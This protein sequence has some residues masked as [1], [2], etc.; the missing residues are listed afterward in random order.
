MYRTKA[1]HLIDDLPFFM[2]LPIV[3]VAQLGSDELAVQ[4]GDIADAYALGTLGLA[5]A[6]VGAVTESQLI[7][8][9]EHSLGATGSLYLTLREQSKLAYLGTYKQHS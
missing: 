2:F 9:G 3:S 7:H 8:L 5:G 1:G 4:A 6:G